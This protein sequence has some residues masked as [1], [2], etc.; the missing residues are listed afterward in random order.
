MSILDDLGKWVD[1]FRSRPKPVSYVVV[2]PMM[3]WGVKDDKDG[4]GRRYLQCPA[5]V[6]EG[7]KFVKHG[8]VESPSA[9]SNPLG[10]FGIPVYR[11]EDMAPDWPGLGVDH[12]P[13][14]TE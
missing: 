2:D 3:H 14:V 6:L 11:L 10:T 12:A 7:M 9:V 5:S 1:E 13:E 4:L 8:D